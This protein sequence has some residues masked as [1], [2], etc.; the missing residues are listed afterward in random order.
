MNAGQPSDSSDLSELPKPGKVFRGYQI[1]ERLGQGGM[2]TVFKARHLHLDRLVAIKVIRQDRPIL[3]EIKQRF[4]RE[5]RAAARLSHPNVVAVYDAGL[6]GDTSYLVMEYLEGVDLGSLVR[7][8]GPLPLSSA[9]RFAL[10]AALGL[11]HVHARGLVHRDIKP[12]N[13]F[14]IRSGRTVKLIDLGLARLPRGVEADA[15]VSELTQSGHILGTIDFMA[16]EQANDSRQAD[17]RADIYSLGCTLYYLLTGSPPFP[18]GTLIEKLL[19]HQN[20]TPTAIESRRPDVSSALAEII[21]Q[22]MAR[23]PEDRYQTPAELA[24]AL[25]PFSLEAE[26]IAVPSARE[27][28]CKQPSTITATPAA[29]TVTLEK[30]APTQTGKR[31]IRDRVHGLPRTRI[32][33][34]AAFALVLLTLSSGIFWLYRGKSATFVSHPDSH[35][36]ENG[37]KADGGQKGGENVKQS[38]VPVVVRAVDP[39]E[40]LPEEIFAAKPAGDLAAVLGD[41]RWRPWG[42]VRCLAISRDGRF[43]ACTCERPSIYLWE[44]ATGN[45]VRVLRGHKNQVTGLAFDRAGNLY[46]AGQ[47]N[48]IKHWQTTS[49]QVKTTWN[50][51]SG[52]FSLAL[53]EDDSLLALACVDGKVRLWDTKRGERIA[54]FEG[55]TKS[56]IT[57]AFSPD[58]AM[59]A[60]SGDDGTIRLW[61]LR[62]QSAGPILQGHKQHVFCLAFSP[63]S[64]ELASGGIDGDLLL[65]SIP[66][67]KVSRRLPHSPTEARIYA[68]VYLPGGLLATSDHFGVIHLWEPALSK[69]LQV[70]EGHAGPVRALAFHPQGKLLFSGGDDS[71]V[72][73]WSMPDGKEEPT[74]DG[75]M[76][77]VSCLA[78]RSD[79]K[80]IA[81][82]GLDTHVR[83]WDLQ[84]RTSLANLRAHRGG[85]ISAAFLPG[86][87]QLASGGF[88]GIIKLWNTRD[89]GQLGDLVDQMEDFPYG[90]AF[91]ADGQT[92]AIAERSRNVLLWKVLERKLQRKL[93]V[94]SGSLGAI[95]WSPQ[96]KLLAVG[97]GDWETPGK[98]L[99]WDVDTDRLQRTIPGHGRA[100]SRVAFSPDGRT[101]VS[102]G[103]DKE[104]VL[105]DVTSGQPRVQCRGHTSAVIGFAVLERMAATADRDGHIY[106]WNAQTGQC[107]AGWSMPGEIRCLALVPGS[108]FLV[109]GNI[110]GTLA[111]LRL[112]EGVP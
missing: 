69:R 71:T 81:S 47:D 63:D 77:P 48:L 15:A 79:G 43:V 49:G 11:D 2:G 21:R 22:M 45:L 16:P 60:S 96:E 111:I 88:D 39:K 112:P 36:L 44:A 99:L 68:V 66:E 25:V 86:T 104:V 78:V 110:N 107:L 92:A 90:L 102:S 101:L 17:I 54:V 72:R 28:E 5:A 14:L 7:Q 34:L 23:R 42:E 41:P 100:V 9:C 106:L 8:Q 61:N 56:V 13:L 103:W 59:L 109:S 20:E 62:T 82:G 58:G 3:P 94:I 84:Q 19:R 10:Q 64:R 24:Q 12:A 40:I 57:V 1:L 52:A 35:Q 74:G 108:S 91:T 70:L 105:W 51:E 26:T 85:V 18:G 89:N 83:L 50:D 29:S 76:G 55:P 95:A 75:H 98:I 65:W 31:D 93:S 53:A 87:D 4:Q 97:Q 6:I 27:P 32:G 46:S 80:R 30:S 37:D 67:R 33:V 38:L 73:R